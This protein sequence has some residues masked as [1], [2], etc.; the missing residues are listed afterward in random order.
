LPIK[1]YQDN[2]LEIKR[3]EEEDKKRAKE[4]LAAAARKMRI[5][6]LLRGKAAF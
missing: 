1:M 6:A 4:P 3:K 2:L 5:V